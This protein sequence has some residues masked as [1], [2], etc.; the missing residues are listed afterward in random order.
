[1]VLSRVRRTSHSLMSRYAAVEPG[2]VV[3]V[4]CCGCSCSQRGLSDL[5]WIVLID[6]PAP[7]HSLLSLDYA[8]GAG[9]GGEPSPRL[10]RRQQRR[11]VH[12]RFIT[13]DSLHTG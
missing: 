12:T 1:M 5:S 11:Y 13:Q 6:L 3:V 2:R 8:P 9:R 7:A 4:V 10:R